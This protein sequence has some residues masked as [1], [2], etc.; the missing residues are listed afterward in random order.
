MY[1][2]AGKVVIP[3]SGICANYARCWGITDFNS[4][5]ILILS[6]GLQQNLIKHPCK[7]GIF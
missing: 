7:C 3:Y 2:E 6:F 4:T 5:V 1:D